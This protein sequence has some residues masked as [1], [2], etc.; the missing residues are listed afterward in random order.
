MRFSYFYKAALI[1]TIC[2]VYGQEH[3]QHD[4]WIDPFDMVNFDHSS[5]TMIKKERN[6]KDD[7]NEE[8]VANVKDQAE[9]QESTKLPHHEY[10]TKTITTTMSPP[11]ESVPSQPKIKKTPDFVKNRSPE[12]PTCKKDDVG[13]VILKK[14]VN[15]MLYHFKGMHPE[16]DSQEYNVWIHLTKAHMDILS[17]YGETKNVSIHDVDEVLSNMIHS[18]TLSHRDAVTKTSMWF[19][20]RTGISLDNFLKQAEIKQQTVAMKDAPAKCIQNA[21]DRS[22]LD[23]IKSVASFEEDE[24]QEYYQHMLI[25]PL[26]KVPP[27]KAVGIT[28]VRFFISPLKDIGGAFSEFLRALFKDLPVT[29]YPVAITVLS[30]VLFLFLF[31]WFGYSVRLP[32]FLG[33]IEPTYNVSGVVDGNVMAAIEE[34]SRKMMEQMKA[35]ENVVSSTDQAMNDKM[36]HMEKIQM[37]A[38]EYTAAASAGNCPPPTLPLER[39]DFK[40]VRAQNV[41]GVKTKTVALCSDSNVPNV[42]DN[43]VEAK[44]RN[45]N[46]KSNKVFRDTDNSVE[47][48][49]ISCTDDASVSEND[50]LNMSENDGLNMSENNEISLNSDTHDFHVVSSDTFERSNG[51]Y[52]DGVTI[53]TIQSSSQ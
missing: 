12:K 31:M 2:E 34:N 6:N 49:G 4:D 16:S 38:I 40:F 50:G 46:L 5:K 42:S 22:L 9:H 18:V 26:F 3:D 36:L 33:S 45:K 28:F 51:N 44:R 19:E 41:I 17:K 35:L 13:S 39:G 47:N 20:S 52:D 8:K 27:T 48:V 25:D 37:T 53:E 32:F 14:F 1:L 29:F 43:I 24:C 30:V 21:E 10:A 15:N 11:T 7:V 23:M